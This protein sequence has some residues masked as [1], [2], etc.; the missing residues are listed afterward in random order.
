MDMSKINTQLLNAIEKELD[1]RDKRF[2]FLKLEY[3]FVIPKAQLEGTIEYCSYSIYIEIDKHSLLSELKRT[4]ELKFG[5]R[6]N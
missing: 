1:T 4:F 3:P 5:Y 2:M 6:F